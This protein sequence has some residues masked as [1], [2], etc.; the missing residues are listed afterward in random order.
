LI[1]FLRTSRGHILRDVSELDSVLR[2]ELLAAKEATLEERLKMEEVLCSVERFRQVGRLEEKFP[3]DNQALAKVYNTV[4]HLRKQAR[5][6]VIQNPDDNMREYYIALLF[7][8][9]NTLRFYDLSVE[10]REHALL[11]ASLLADRLGL[12]G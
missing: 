9:M 6:L 2:F 1:D 12:K 4:V 10:Q 8:A 7:H 11:C 5:K 3:A